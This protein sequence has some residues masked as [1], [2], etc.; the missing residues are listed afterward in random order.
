RGPG[1][2]FGVRQ[3]GFPDFRMADLGDAK[4]VGAAREAA[5]ELLRRDPDLSRPEHRLLAGRVEELRRAESS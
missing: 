2:Y 1:E 3:S 5:A 4:L